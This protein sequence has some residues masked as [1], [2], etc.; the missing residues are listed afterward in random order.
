MKTHALQRYNFAN[1]LAYLT[2]IYLF[3]PDPVENPIYIVM[4]PDPRWSKF[5]L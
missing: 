1:R 2:Q 4:D 3:L 5:I